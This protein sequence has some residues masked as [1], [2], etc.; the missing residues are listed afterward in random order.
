M[1]A[2]ARSKYACFVGAALFLHVVSACEENP[3]SV[4]CCTEFK[5]G[6]D[7]SSA[8][9]GLTGEVRGQFL[10]F[11]QASSDLAS[12]AAGALQDVQTAC[13]NIAIELGADPAA[14]A[15][16]DAKPD[17][18]RTS[19]L[20][21]LAAGQISTRVTARVHVDV[22]YQAPVCEISVQARARCEGSCTASG[23]C[24]LRANPPVC[25]GGTLE[26]AC[27]GDCN[28]KVGQP[29][30]HCEGSCTGNCKGSCVAQAGVR[31]NGRCD[32]TC[33]AEGSA[34]GQAFDANGNCIGTCQGT[35]AMTADG[36]R[37]TG[38]CNG[39]CDATCR[40]EANATITCDGDCTGSW[41]PLRCTGG[42]LEGGCDVQGSCKANCDASAAARAECRPP[43]VRVLAQ[44]TV[45]PELGRAIQ[46]LEA[47]LPQLIVVLKARGE[48][49]VDLVARLATSTAETGSAVVNG[50]LSARA[51][52]CLLPIGATIGEAAANAKVSVQAS[53][54]VLGSLGVQ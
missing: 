28:A 37:C 42:T 18:D 21:Q 40:A 39:S 45:D 8:D 13:R 17:R 16:A 27:R 51:T 35:C 30:V 31:C 5:V 53:G 15:A 36:V 19:D 3:L 10:A 9:F 52:A 44:A 48:T 12:T 32:G 2:A 46:V 14:V 54:D 41:E 1:A 4:L 24:D 33:T 38:A 43:A 23:Q 47:N 49:F 22:A 50:N 34:T 29:T 11:A 20:C 25:T 26:I 7:L 6:A